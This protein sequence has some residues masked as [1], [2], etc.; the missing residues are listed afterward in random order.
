M[1]TVSKK[2]PIIL[3]IFLFLKMQVAFSQQLDQEVK[4]A[5]SLFKLKKY[6]EAL[7][8]YEKSYE[9]KGIYTAQMLIKM[10]FIHEG[11]DNFPKTLFYLNQYYL[12]SNDKNALEKMEDLAEKHQLKGYEYSDFKFIFNLIRFYKDQISFIFIIFIAIAVACILY[13]KYR[14]GIVLKVA[15]IFTLSLLIVFFSINFFINYYSPALVT[16]NTYLMSGPSAGADVLGAM[17]AGN[18]ITVLGD[19]DIWMK[20]AV[21]GQEGYIRKTNIHLLR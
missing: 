17:K 11:L 14:R 18:K 13:I 3:I 9:E 2:N 1:Q 21:D 4:D 15:A 8:I 20:I 19:E 12:L 6:T 10:A 5:D 7:K 16:N